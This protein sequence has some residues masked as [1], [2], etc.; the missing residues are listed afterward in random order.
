MARKKIK[1]NS[2]LYNRAVTYAEIA[3]YA[4]VDEF[5]SHM[6]EKELTRIDE[7]NATAEQVEK[8]L[9]GLGYID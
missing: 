2:E 8:K 4:S 6:V 7:E 3:G 1:L 5:I 9:R